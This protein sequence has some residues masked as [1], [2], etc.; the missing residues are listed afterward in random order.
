MTD[1]KGST[2]SN[3][4]RG[5]KE[6]L[7]EQVERLEDDLTRSKKLVEISERMA[8]ADTLDESLEEFLKIIQVETRAERATLFLND[9]ARGELYSR[10]LIGDYHREIRILNT[11]GIA[12]H[13]FQN[14]KSIIVNNPYED[15]RFDKTVDER[16]GLKTESVLCAPIMVG[17]RECLGVAQVI[18]N[19]DQAFIEE[20]KLFLELMAN[21]AALVLKSLQTVQKMREKRKQEIAFL[22]VV[23][24]ITSEIQLSSLLNKVMTEAT[25]LLEADRGTLFL[26]DDKTDELY[27]EIGEGLGVKQIRLPNT[28]GIA[29]AVFSSGKSVNIPY[30]YADLRFNPE[31]DKKTGYFTRSILCVPVINNKGRVIGV[32]Q[33]LNKRGGSFNEEDEARLKAFTGQI[34]IAL[35]NAKLFNDIQRMKNY[36]ESMLESMSNAV[37]TIDKNK[38][39]ATCN[40]AGSKLF[41]KRRTEDLIGSNFDEIF[42]EQV[43]LLEKV[44]KVLETG[45]PDVMV[46]VYI[47]WEDTTLSLNMTLSELCDAEGERIGALVMIEDV[48]REKRLKSTMSRYMDSGIAEQ[49]LGQG[50]E[51]LGGRDVMATILFSDVRSFT[52]LTE[53]LGAQGTVTMLNEYFTIM[54]D[55][56]QAE[57]GMLDKF[58][59]DAIMAAFGLPISHDDNEDRAMRCAISMHR[60]LGLWNKER[61]RRGDRPLRIGIGLNTDKVVA[62]NIGSPKRM[63]YTVIGDGVNLAARLES[64]SKQYCA[65]LL[66]SEFTRERL[67]GTY[68][69]RE[70][71]SVVVKGKTEPVKI[72]EVLDFYTEEEFPNVHDVVA[73]FQRA[74]H[75][76]LSQHFDDAISAFRDVLALNP[77]DGLAELYIE[78]SEFMKANPP[79]EDW[80][81]VWTLTSK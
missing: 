39:V 50:S 12:G 47:E 26:N 48:S 34:S 65:G 19:H 22:D 16:T 28:S 18:N 52:T 43:W 6:T 1:S 3:K 73:T 79:G 23:A 76:Y 71:D 77:N 44:D 49:L 4:R 64:A 29:G 10:V 42:R 36:N 66:I 37:M 35:E 53:E 58:I 33:I 72:H 21:Q 46:D 45:E 41:K 15:E 81:G 61:V 38:V 68:R 69:L 75:H 27:T 30:A 70:V 13:V 17:E 32:T 11:D 56:I 59:G 14:R 60:E 78:R 63:D 51:V 62:G 25:R 5:K 7:R 9:E 2:T 67:K 40:Q 80:D 54:V 31:F 57:G 74:R 8:A 55:C 24:D 20:Q